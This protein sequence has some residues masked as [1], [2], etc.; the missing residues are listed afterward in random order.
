MI[1][2]NVYAA[3]VDEVER[4]SR[5]VAGLRAENAELH[6]ENATTDRELASLAL[7]SDHADEAK[8]A[9]T[10]CVVCDVERELDELR[11]RG[12]GPLADVGAVP[13]FPLPVVWQSSD[14]RGEYGQL[15]TADGVLLGSDLPAAWARFI[16]DA[17]NAAHPSVSAG[18]SAV[19]PAP[20]EPAT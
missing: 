5:E 10:G 9:P 15:F 16:R 17:L 6:R 2:P 18:D 3:R 20:T 12:A 8:E 14:N 1:D 11:G 7:C 4:L 19:L 13:P